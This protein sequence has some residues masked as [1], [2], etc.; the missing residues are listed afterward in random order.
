MRGKA[1][2]TAGRNL[3]LCLL[4]KG[5]PACAPETQSVMQVVTVDDYD[6]YCHYVAGLVGIGLS[7]LFGK[8]WVSVSGRLFGWVG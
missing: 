6:K 3:C 7:K 2:R 1:A 4:Q 8:Q 5:A